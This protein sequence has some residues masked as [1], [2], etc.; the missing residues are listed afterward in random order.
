MDAG[1]RRITAQDRRKRA[2]NSGV[3]VDVSEVKRA[4]FRLEQLAKRL[5][6][7]EEEERK[8]ISR[9]LH[10]DIG[11]RVALPGD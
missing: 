7:R 3:T 1:K 11:Q 10:D 9:E 6:K 8:R 5:M 2:E 4:Q